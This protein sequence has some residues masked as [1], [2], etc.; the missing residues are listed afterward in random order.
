LR[1]AGTGGNRTPSARSRTPW[2]HTGA[3]P[4]R[5]SPN[6]GCGRNQRMSAAAGAWGVL[7]PSGRRRGCGRARRCR[8]APPRWWRPAAC[9]R[10]AAPRA[11]ARLACCVHASLTWTRE[12]QGEREPAEGDLSPPGD[13]AASPPIAEGAWP[14]PEGAAAA[15]ARAG[16]A[17]PQRHDAG[18]CVSRPLVIALTGRCLMPCVGGA[19]RRTTRASTAGLTR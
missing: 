16:P 18:W 6:A 15:A 10:C 8:G 2:V 13:G 19:G 17:G 14:E 3:P 12:L 5:P 9:C 11:F 4:R 1:A 7:A